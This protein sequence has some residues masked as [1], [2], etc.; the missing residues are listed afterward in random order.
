[1]HQAQL[2]ILHAHLPSFNYRAGLL[3]SETL[4]ILF[5]RQTSTE[6]VLQDNSYYQITLRNH[7]AQR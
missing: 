1:M 3:I 4:A 6:E 7:V 2:I 5:T